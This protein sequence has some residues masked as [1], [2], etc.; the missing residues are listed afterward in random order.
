MI[1]DFLRSFVGEPPAI[2]SLANIP[3][4]IEYVSAVGILIGMVYLILHCV[5]SLMSIF[6][7]GR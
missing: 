5:F 1:I 2:L 4:L 3:S 6:K 7:K